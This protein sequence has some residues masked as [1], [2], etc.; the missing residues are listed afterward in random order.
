MRPWNYAKVT[1]ICAQCGNGF[2]T[3]RKSAAIHCGDL[4]ARKTQAAKRRKPLPVGSCGVCG[5][6]FSHRHKG[7]SAQLFCGP[8]C[9]A[10]SRRGRAPTNKRPRVVIICASCSRPIILPEGTKRRY[11]SR[12]CHALA[13]RGTVAWNRKDRV[14]VHCRACG[15]AVNESRREPQHSYSARAYA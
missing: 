13:K 1:K 6:A 4:C 9:L 5:Q 15:V 11:C 2:L 3:N 10:I 14:T 7:K 12:D 8:A